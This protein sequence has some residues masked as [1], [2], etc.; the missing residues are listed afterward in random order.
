M[1]TCESCKWDIDGEDPCE[2]G[3]SVVGGH[4]GPTFGCTL[5]EGKPVEFEGVVFEAGQLRG[6][7]PVIY[8][9]NRQNLT[10]DKVGRK[11]RVRLEYV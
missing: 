2:M 8:E 3:V 9:V 6:G 10:C 1:N 7:V 5:W 4:G 11:V